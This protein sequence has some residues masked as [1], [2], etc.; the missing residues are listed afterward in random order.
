[1]GLSF[2][3]LVKMGGGRRKA[4]LQINP[5]KCKLE[6][7]NQNLTE[8]AVSSWIKLPREVM[9]SS[10][11]DLSWRASFSRRPQHEN[12]GKIQQKVIGIFSPWNLMNM[13]KKRA[14]SVNQRQ[15]FAGKQVTPGHW[16]WNGNIISPTVFQCEQTAEI[17]SFCSIPS[18]DALSPW[19]ATW[20]P[21]ADYCRREYLC[22]LET[23][24]W[25]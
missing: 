11:L 17:I 12:N 1:M 4:E 14:E 23:A 24:W 22:P 8:R 3:Q 15:A 6:I 9:D 16:Q 5:E 19:P 18:N 13:W 10:P 7:S 21:A 25:G 2:Y 20:V